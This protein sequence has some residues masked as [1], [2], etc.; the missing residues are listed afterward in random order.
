MERLSAVGIGPAAP[1][2]AAAPPPCGPYMQKPVPRQEWYPT[3]QPR[4]YAPVHMQAQHTGPQTAP[5]P[6]YAS[7]MTYPTRTG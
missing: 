6:S 5:A 3:A 4:P 1:S 2:R 7:N